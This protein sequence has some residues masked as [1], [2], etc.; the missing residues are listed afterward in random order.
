MCGGGSAGDNGVEWSTGSDDE[1]AGNA[2]F[3]AE[4]ADF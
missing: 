2:E 3:R 1:S 4:C